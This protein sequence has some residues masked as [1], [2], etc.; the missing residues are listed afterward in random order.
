MA[1]K[2][3]HIVPFVGQD[4]ESDI[5]LFFT[6]NENEP[7]RLNV[8][9]AI[10]GDESFSGNALNYS[11][12]DLKDFISACSKTPLTPLPFAFSTKVTADGGIIESEF[13]EMDGLVFSYQ[14]IY[15]DGFV[16]P[17]ASF[18]LVA[19]PPS[20][21]NLGKR[22]ISDVTIENTCVLDVPKQSSEV[23]RVRLLFKEGDFGTWKIIDEV[24]TKV[25]Q[26][27]EFFTFT[28]ESE[29][30]VGK[31]DFMAN[32]VYAVL[33]LDE[34]S[35]NYDS[36]PQVAQAQTITGNRLMYGN[37]IEGFDSVQASASSSLEYK[38]RP[39][40]LVSFSLVA[41]PL[42]SQ[43]SE[44]PDFIGNEGAS[45]GFVIDGS[46]VPDQIPTGTYEIQIS[47]R[48]QR[49]LHIYNT[50]G[51][52]YRGSKNISTPNGLDFSA[53]P[54]IDS[55]SSYPPPPLETPGGDSLIATPL[56]SKNDGVA[57]VYRHGG[58]S[59]ASTRIG[60]TASS[61]L[62]LDVNNILVKMVFEVEEG[63]QI[64]SS[65]LVSIVA[66]VL[67]GST[68]NPVDVLEALN[69]N[70]ISVQ[71]QEDFDVS[72][73]LH[74]DIEINSG[75][76]SGDIF[77]QTSS[78]AELIM[79]APDSD[80]NR[81]EGFFII[82]KA[83][84]KIG[85]EASP[86]LDNLSGT[87]RGISI[88]VANVDVASMLNCFPAPAKGLG[89]LP[90]Y[91]D[92]DYGDEDTF[93]SGPD[94][95]WQLRTQN[96]PGQATPNRVFWPLSTGVSFKDAS[97]PATSIVSQPDGEDDLLDGGV[98]PY[99]IGEWLVL[100][101]N[102]TFNDLYEDFYSVTATGIQGTNFAG[103]ADPGLSE[104]TFH[105]GNLGYL[106]PTVYSGGS[107]SLTGN[108]NLN[109]TGDFVLS[110]DSSP[111]RRWGG[112]VDQF[113]FLAADE[114]DPSNNLSF[115]LAK[116]K[117]SVVDGDVG[118]GGRMNIDTPFSDLSVGADGLL[119]AETHLTHAPSSA[120]DS[121]GSIVNPKYNRWGSVWSDTIYGYVSNMPFLSP[122]KIYSSVTESDDLESLDPIK[123]GAFESSPA[124]HLT[125]T[126]SLS[127][128]GGLS[129]SFKTRA[130]H[131]FG[132][133]YYDQRGR[134]G[135]VNK[136]SS[137]YVPG[138]SD[139]ERASGVPKGAVAIKLKLNHSPPSWA[140]D[141]RVFYSNRNNSKRFIQYSA[142]DAFTKKGTSANKN[143]IYVSLAHLQGHPASYA[144]SYN[145]RT[146]DTDEPTLYRPSQGDKLRVIS[147]YINDTTRV[148]ADDSAIFDVS[149]LQFL[150][151]QMADHPLYPL[152]ESDADVKI[153]RNG[154]FV[155]LKNNESA[156]GFTT[157]DLDNN[158]SL[159]G[160]RVVFEIVSPQKETLDAAHPY[161]E[162]Q[163]G[164]KVL[165]LFNDNGE[166]LLD[167]NGAATYAHE[168]E[169]MLVES[170]DVFFRGVPVNIQEYSTTDSEFKSIIDADAEGND[171]SISRFKRYHLE[172][173]AVTDLYSTSA[174][175]Y[176][177]PNFVNPLIKKQRQ[178][179]S[180]IFSQKTDPSSFKLK[181]TS[182]PPAEKNYFHL[183]EKYGDVN[184]INGKD[185]Y[186]TSLQEGKI[187]K[188]PLDRAITQ[189]ATGNS[190]MNLS[191]TVLNSGTFSDSD[192][193]TAGNPESVVI[194]D[195]TIYFVDKRN[196]A[197]I[198]L[199]SEGVAVISDLGMKEY[200]KR[201][202]DR[203][204]EASSATNNKDV[205]IVGGY[206][207]AVN[208]IIFTFSKPLGI[209]A[210]SYSGISLAGNATNSPL[211]L[212]N[213]APLEEFRDESQEPF[214]NTIAFDHLGKKAWKT[215]YSYNAPNYARVNNK[216]ISFKD[217][218]GELVWLHG[219]N[220]KRNCF[221]GLSY[222][223]MLKT[224]SNSKLPSTNK[225]FRAISFEGNS[226]WPS[227]I[228][229]SQEKTKVASFN[230]YEGL[231]ASDIK[232]SFNESVS[233]SNVLSV[234]VVKSFKILDV[235]LPVSVGRL[236]VTFK[237]PVNRYPLNLGEQ[238]QVYFLSE[239]EGTDSVLIP[240]TPVSI[241]G[242]HTIRYSLSDP[243]DFD[244]LL[245]GTIIHKSSS[246]IFG[247]TLR[248]KFATI[249][250][251]NNS[252]EPV[253]LYAINVEAIPSKL[254][255]SS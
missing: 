113:T 26:S 180:I 41:T 130:T 211:V 167:E 170:G 98:L 87:K 255:A 199:T 48:P 50:E 137:V 245:N 193:G 176:G 209:N 210:V 247:D 55:D 196:K 242:T 201:Q 231:E 127:G 207:P 151:N 218:M 44:H 72:L 182:F 3:T 51:N 6:D 76:E 238:V 233:S 226:K 126:S 187:S 78:R 107:T 159:W 118:P 133:V 237:S 16:S 61:P 254:D 183:P 128:L 140:S 105:V 5:I 156:L 165:E 139:S 12:D 246:A 117:Y 91:I 56:F 19:Y 32:R 83:S 22:T 30:L 240:M 129:T 172:T 208:E 171:I 15:E 220:E 188:I 191:E 10:E 236:A 64:T 134:S 25:E 229:T 154:S 59:V 75:L 84:V 204:L 39:K 111:S 112:R 217:T 157:I 148:W 53:N 146:H 173:E 239:S 166:P 192:F 43:N 54:S 93:Y 186:V 23:A 119:E 175:G 63:A 66:S 169:E 70:L 124:Q 60:T 85:F 20:L 163:Y 24:S 222:L 77:N 142:A 235:G 99:R 1:F 214:V 38:E 161:F 177:K 198:S 212:V 131:D 100:N 4:E 27:N 224:T 57:N 49:N 94:W 29:T 106:F 227:I 114:L 138:Y 144:N 253:E 90:H 45:T 35:K 47:I 2:D 121:D 67:T 223:S 225:E 46:G 249:T 181:Y 174:K 162:T 202:I 152:S 243:V 132:I 185:E 82:N 65:Q 234:G 108:N 216:F 190:T 197:V 164:G 143:D 95:P 8:R 71:G 9:R 230:R 40:D 62:I 21:I 13:K 194:A 120:T 102:D 206:N 241:L 101:Y 104:K 116:Q 248:D 215:R 42:F 232:G 153:R 200:F 37:Y 33:A 86:S 80:L 184:Y 135:A 158:L 115:P 79:C 11:G 89:N 58:T 34:A 74:T 96:S 123:K 81:P 36:V 68:G 250:S 122:A 195:G 17:I 145:A 92:G 69:V 109:L 88:K 213:P 7:K 205:R 178:Q 221:H 147:Y 18:S 28:P 149:G 150:D 160:N 141:Y 110:P 252:E 31:F 52:G 73:G 244:E 103:T 251:Y 189:T 125:I 179:S 168:N 155:V 228:K 14:N 136:L 203:L 97:V 219:A